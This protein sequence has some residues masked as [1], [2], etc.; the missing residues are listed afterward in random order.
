[1]AKIEF[2]FDEMM[3]RPT[4]IELNR[5]GYRVVMAV[6]VGMTKKVMMSTWLTRASITWS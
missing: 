5:L 4:A 3:N 2:Y 1:M 6:D